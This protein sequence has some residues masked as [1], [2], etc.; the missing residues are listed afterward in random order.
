MFV[1]CHIDF[2]NIEAL[3]IR[4]TKKDAINAAIE[5]MQEY[6]LDGLAEQRNITKK[7]AEKIARDELISGGCIYGGTDDY[8]ISIQESI[9]DE[10]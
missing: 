3:I 4:K 5:Y 1:V 6:W 10:T 8:Y 7:E 9:K 2:N